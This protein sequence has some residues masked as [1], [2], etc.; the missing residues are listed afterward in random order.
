MPQINSPEEAF[1]YTYFQALKAWNET[2]SD[3]RHG[4]WDELTKEQRDDL[5]AGV[6]FVQRNP[7]CTPQ[8]IHERW[9]R[10]KRAQGWVLG[11]ELDVEAKT[12]PRMVEW[13]QADIYDRIKSG[14]LLGVVAAVSQE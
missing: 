8:D 11:E 9:L 10:A 7:G 5:V 3:F 1:A 14:L 13:D 2:A 12:H 4:E 6:M